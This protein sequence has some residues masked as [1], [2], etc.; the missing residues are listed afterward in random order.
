[1]LT[2]AA[3]T[4]RVDDLV[5]EALAQLPGAHA[6]KIAGDPA[7]CDDPTDGGPPGR[8]I[9]VAEYQI[10]EP[11]PDHLDRL[12][13]WWTAHGFEVLRDARPRGS[14]IWVENRAD[15]FRMA[16]QGNDAG[17]LFLTATSPCVWP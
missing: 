17:G 12:H 8:F 6:D 11:G 13:E 4:Q 2:L 3:A 10:R 16:V 14:Y 9:A 15:G 5:R 7:P 1:V